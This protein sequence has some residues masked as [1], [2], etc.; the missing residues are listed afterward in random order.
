MI[1]IKNI[2]VVLLI[3]F[4]FESCIIKKNKTKDWSIDFIINNRH[5]LDSYYVNS[6]GEGIRMIRDVDCNVQLEKYNYEK[7]EALKIYKAILSLQKKNMDWECSDNSIKDGINAK[8]LLREEQVEKTIELPYC[9]I[10][11]SSDEFMFILLL[12]ESIAK[13]KK[14]ERILESYIV[15]PPPLIY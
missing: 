3:S 1:R 8:V 6:R 11:Q 14:K 10:E 7:E 9:V 5:T 12:F 4:V 13:D 15:P 2:I